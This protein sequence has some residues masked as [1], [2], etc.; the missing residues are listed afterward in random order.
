M[1]LFYSVDWYKST[2]A[3]LLEPDV[4]VEEEIVVAQPKR[5]IVASVATRA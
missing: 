4:L 3:D 5:K 2:D 1:F